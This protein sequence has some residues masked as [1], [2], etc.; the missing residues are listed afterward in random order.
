MRVDI[1]SGSAAEE[2]RE[3]E[4]KDMRERDRGVAVPSRELAW[5]RGRLGAKGPKASG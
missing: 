5:L 4:V 2:R 3:E 1:E